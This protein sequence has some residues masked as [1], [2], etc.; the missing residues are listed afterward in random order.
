MCFRDYKRTQAG[1]QA[2]RQAGEQS[3]NQAYGKSL[4]RQDHRT[5][6]IS[7]PHTAVTKS[8]VPTSTRT[9]NFCFLNATLFFRL[10]AISCR[11]SGDKLAISTSG[12]HSSI[13][14]GEHR[15]NIWKKRCNPEKIG[16]S[17]VW[18]AGQHTHGCRLHIS[19]GRTL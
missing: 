12:V 6:T 18:P 3:S 11:A 15:R 8:W 7:Q 2:G 10:I 17:T 4:A 5:S 1:R 14:R 13:C 16:N 9:L 19:Q